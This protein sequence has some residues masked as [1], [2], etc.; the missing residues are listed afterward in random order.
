MDP[1]HQR[2][3]ADTVV[4]LF[5]CHRD[6]ERAAFAV[7]AEVDFGGRSASGWAEDVIVR[8]VRPVDPPFRLRRRVLVSADDGGADLRQRVDVADGLGVGLDLLQAR[9]DTPSRA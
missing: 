5:W 8:F 7:T 9:V 4:A 6:R 3:R 1:F 2:P